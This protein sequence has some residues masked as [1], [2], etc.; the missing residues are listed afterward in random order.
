MK[1]GLIDGWKSLARLFQFIAVYAIAVA[2]VLYL[3]PIAGLFLEGRYD[4]MSSSVKF[5][6]IIGFFMVVA[7]WQIV[8]HRERISASLRSQN[9]DRIASI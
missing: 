2:A 4:A 5:F 3:L 8:G 7:V 1:N 6:S 9:Q